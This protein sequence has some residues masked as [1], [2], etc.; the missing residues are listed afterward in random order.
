[1]T[2]SIATGFTSTPISGVSNPSITVPLQNWAMDFGVQVDDPGECAVTELT[3][4]TDQ[5]A[6]VRVSQRANSNV[7]AKSDIDPTAYLPSRSGTDTLIERRET[8]AE[9]DSTDATYRKLIPVRCGIT[10]QVPAYGNI[11]DAQV[12]DLVKRTLAGIYDSSGTSAIDVV[13]PI[14]HGVLKKKTL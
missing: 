13:S 9:T 1:M 12:L 11:T 5:P 6:L 4:L 14:L 8:W 3:A 7:Y 2:K 10:I